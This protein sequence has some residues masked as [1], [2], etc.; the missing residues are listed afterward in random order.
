VPL[1][2]RGDFEFLKVKERLSGGGTF[3]TGR[4]ACAS[5]SRDMHVEKRLSTKNL[6]TSFSIGSTS[7]GCEV[8]RT[9]EVVS[10]SCTLAAYVILS[11][12]NS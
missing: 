8:R 5:Y 11:R 10:K 6:S 12:P 2:V 7:K 3:E 4:S 9:S 1:I